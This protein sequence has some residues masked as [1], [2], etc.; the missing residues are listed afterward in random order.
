[1]GYSLNNTIDESC[2]VSEG[3]AEKQSCDLVEK[4]FVEIEGDS[5]GS[6]QSEKYR[7]FVCKILRI[8]LHYVNL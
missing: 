2:G 4:E 6:D 7:T 1:M 3:K 5:I 8:S